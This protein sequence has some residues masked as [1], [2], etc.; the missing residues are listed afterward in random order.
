MTDFV[1][2]RRIAHD[3]PVLGNPSD[4]RDLLDGGCN[5]IVNQWIDSAALRGAAKR[6]L[7]L[8]LPESPGRVLQGV[9]N[10]RVI[11]VPSEERIKAP[12]SWHGYQESVYIYTWNQDDS[13]LLELL[14]PVLDVV[15]QVSGM[16]PETIH[17]KPEDGVVARIQLIHYPS[18]SGYISP[19][20]D[21]LRVSRC[22]AGVYVTEFGTDYDSGGFYAIDADGRRHEVDK[23]MQSGDVL[24]FSPGIVHGVDPVQAPTGA[25][26]RTFVA[27]N[28]IESH[29]VVDRVGTV[30]VDFET[31]PSG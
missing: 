25:P 2:A 11:N 7:S 12:G 28:L 27:V 19:H 18:G 9:G 4:V 3:D 29:H 17:A 6:A 1:E 22:A 10:S 30:G 20:R 16:P 26:G 24:L 13:G 23:F 14:R 8:D 5:L 31:H 21:P 15:I